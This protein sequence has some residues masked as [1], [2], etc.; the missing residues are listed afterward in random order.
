MTVLP[1]GAVVNVLTVSSCLVDDPAGSMA[2]AP[3]P[4]PTAPVQSPASDEATKAAE[5]AKAAKRAEI[6]AK[7]AELKILKE[8]EETQKTMYFGDHNGITCDGCGAVPIVGYRYKCKDCANHDICETC[9]DAWAGGKMTNGL[10]KQVV[11]LKAEDH[12]ALC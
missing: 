6:T 3:V 1:S 11:S 5:D 9:Y 4:P 7:L 2:D 12:R 10:G 8:K